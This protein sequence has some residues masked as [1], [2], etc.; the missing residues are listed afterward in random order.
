M[1]KKEEIFVPHSL[2][3]AHTHY[4]PPNDDIIKCRQFGWYEPTKRECGYCI[5]LHPYEAEMCADAVRLRELKQ[6][7]PLMKHNNELAI[8]FINEYKAKYGRWRDGQ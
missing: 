2:E 6:T 4:C 1:K 3:E 8:N 5:Q 7:N